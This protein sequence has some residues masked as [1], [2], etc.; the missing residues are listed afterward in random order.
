MLIS[1]ILTSH[2]RERN[3]SEEQGFVEVAVQLAW[4][5]GRW[6]G[7]VVKNSAWKA[8]SALGEC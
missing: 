1:Y 7:Q 5:T 8:S 2:I 6:T 4:P 3:F